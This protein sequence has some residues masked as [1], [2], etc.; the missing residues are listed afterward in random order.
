MR[1]GQRSADCAADEPTGTDSANG[2]HIM[3][4][5]ESGPPKPRDDADLWLRMTRELAAPWSTGARAS[6]RQGGSIACAW[7]SETRASWRR[8]LF[9]VC[10]AVGV[11]G[12]D[13]LRSADP[14]RSA[15]FGTE[16]KALIAADALPRTNSDWTPETLAHHRPAA[17]ESAPSNSEMVETPTMS[18]DPRTVA[19]RGRI[20]RRVRGFP[21]TARARTQRCAASTRVQE[22][23][24]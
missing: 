2:R 19:R 10:I 24:R 14:E 4:S 11:R 21:S 7:R 16:A 1:A 12:G 22:Q 18:G 13:R 17:Q 15:V 8:S 20:A 5:A 3:D 9:F 23:R 6:R